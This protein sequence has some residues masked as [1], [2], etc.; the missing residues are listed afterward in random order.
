MTSPSGRT[1]ELDR[2]LSDP[3]RLVI[4]SVL[5]VTEWCGFAFLRD[6]VSLSDSALSKQLATLRRDGYV[7]QQRTYIGRVPKTTVRATVEGRQRFI[8]HVEALQMIVERTSR[9]QPE[10]SPHPRPASDPPSDNAHRRG[11]N[12]KPGLSE[13]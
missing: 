3:T 1:P 11:V 5:C 7:E 13:G 4:M 6:A 10:A 12:L 8:G 9:P 2:L